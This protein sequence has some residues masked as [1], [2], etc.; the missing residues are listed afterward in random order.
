MISDIEKARPNRGILV[1]RDQNC[2]KMMAGNMSGRA[3]HQCGIST[4][5]EG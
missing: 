1:S 4:A 5:I 3:P 2:S